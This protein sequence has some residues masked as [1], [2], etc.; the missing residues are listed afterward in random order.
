MREEEITQM[1]ADYLPLIESD[2]DRGLLALA[3]DVE[4]TTRHKAVRLAYDH[5][6]TLNNLNQ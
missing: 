1:I 6:A 3:K 5:V 2:R 4:R